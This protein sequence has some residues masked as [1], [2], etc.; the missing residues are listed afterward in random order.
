[1]VERICGLIHNFF[2]ADEDKHDGT[3][4]V[5]NGAIELP[6][7]VNGQYFRIVGSTL[8]D[9]VYQHPAT[10]LLDETFTG[11]V[12]AMKVPKAIK[13]IASE[14]EE[15]LRNNGTTLNSPYTSENVIGAYSYSKG[16]G[17]SGGAYTWLFGKDGIYGSQLNRWRRLSE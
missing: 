15:L 12:W 14:A 17:A 13:D 10:N 9:G 6:F 3:Y 16:A 5:E 11:E 1:M 4:T 7:L 8:N 2:T